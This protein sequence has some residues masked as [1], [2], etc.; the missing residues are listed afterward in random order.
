LHDVS[1]GAGYTFDYCISFCAEAK[2]CTNKQAAKN[3]AGNK[4]MG[5]T[6]FSGKRSLDRQKEIG[7]TLGE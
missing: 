3:T 2:T 1:F 6:R 5:S 4:K 7:V